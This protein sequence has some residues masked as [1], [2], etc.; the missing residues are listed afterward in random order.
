MPKYAIN[1]AFLADNDTGVVR[2]AKEIVKQIDKLLDPAVE[3]YKN[4]HCLILAPS[5]AK[6]DYFAGLYKNIPVKLIGEK[7]GKVWE[8]TEYAAYLKKTGMIQVNLCNTCPLSLDGGLTVV[9]DIVFKT[10]PE[11]FT[12]KGAWH[13][14]L[15][16]KMMY[17]HAFKTADAVVT[18]SNCA[19][20]EIL[21]KYKLSRPNL[22]VAGNGW[23][24]YED[25]ELDESVF[26][27][28][29]GIVKGDYYYY[30]AS[31]APNKNLKWIV[32]NAKRY[33]DRCYV[34]SGGN[35]GDES[36]VEKLDNCIVTGRVS[37]G[38]AKALMSHCKAFL[39][40]STYEG[41]GIPPMEA[42]SLG[43]SVVAGDIPVLREIYSDTVHFVE[44]DDYDCDID[45]LLKEKVT[46]PDKVLEKY[47]WKKSAEKILDILVEIGRPRVDKEP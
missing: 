39:F 10:H 37:D 13:E 45:L 30:L 11:Y 7:T 9:H 18:V 46:D 44:C 31:L 6:Y 25:I 29:S 15:F 16:R 17:S 23:Q 26:D 12:E 36:G 43:T 27:A 4:V 21:K 19:R 24:H 2:Y 1:G 35:L 3:K 8:Q 40:P 33:K 41:F 47:S 42:L 20:D 14:I 34:I 28:F 32:E 38:Q 5:N 22:T